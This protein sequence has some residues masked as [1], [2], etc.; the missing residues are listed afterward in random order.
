MSSQEKK[1]IQGK[2]CF[3]KDQNMAWKIKN[4]ILKFSKEKNILIYGR[5]LRAKESFVNQMIDLSVEGKYD[6]LYIKDDKNIGF[7]TFIKHIDSIEI[8]FAFHTSR[9][10]FLAKKTFFCAL[11][12]IKKK[13]ECNKFWFSF[14]PR[15][16]FEKYKQFIISYMG[17]SENKKD[18]RFELEI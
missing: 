2:F 4:E 7:A 16:N 6:T 5:T 11:D 17:F 10:I 3:L 15:D 9:D 8:F 14:C 12:I 18:K 13:Y 1:D